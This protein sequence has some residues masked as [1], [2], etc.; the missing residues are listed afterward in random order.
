M[1]RILAAIGIIALVLLALDLVIGDAFGHDWYPASC[2]S[3]RDCGPLSRDLVTETPAGYTLSTGEFIDRKR[4]KF[5]PDGEFH[6]CRFGETQQIICFFVP[7]N[8][9]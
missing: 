3:D 9:S 7:N 5:S 2:C 4:V 6:I 1:T 8:G